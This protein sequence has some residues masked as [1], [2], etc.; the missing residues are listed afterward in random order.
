MVNDDNDHQVVN[1]HDD[2]QLVNDDDNLPSCER[3][4][5][6][7]SCERSGWSSTTLSLSFSG[8]AP[9]S[10]LLWVF[11]LWLFKTTHR[12]TVR[13]GDHH[14]HNHF[15]HPRLGDHYHHIFFISN[16]VN[17]IGSASGVSLQGTFTGFIRDGLQNSEKS[18][19]KSIQAQKKIVLKHQPAWEPQE[20]KKWS[21]IWTNSDTN[22]AETPGQLESHSAKK[23][24]SVWKNTNTN[25]A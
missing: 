19:M 15:D 12:L 8:S 21:S 1:D 22:T 4:E 2:H 16:V 17:F 7:P 23:C 24:S 25:T 11:H 20:L 6:S 18:I 10:V 9:R 13:L 5:W 3:S 14:N